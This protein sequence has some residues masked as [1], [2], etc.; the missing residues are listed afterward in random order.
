MAITKRMSINK[1]IQPTHWLGCGCDQCKKERLARLE[2]KSLPAGNGHS[3]HCS[4][5]QCKKPYQQMPY[6]YQVTESCKHFRQPV[7]VGDFTVTCSAWRD[8]PKGNDKEK[9]LETIKTPDIGIYL[10]SLWSDIV[11]PVK[12]SPGLNDFPVCKAFYPTILFPWRDRGMPSDVMLKELMEY[13]IKKIKEGKSI[14]IGCHGGH[15]RTGT[16]VACLLTQLTN[17]S[18][19][20]IITY[21]RTQYCKEAIEGYVQEDAIYKLKGEEPPKIEKPA[22]TTTC[23]S[24]STKED[25][26]ITKMKKLPARSRILLLEKEEGHY[27]YACSECTITI[28]AK[29][30]LYHSCDWKYKCC[31]LCYTAMEKQAAEDVTSEQWEMFVCNLK[32]SYLTCSSCEVPILYSDKLWAKDDSWTVIMCD[33]CYSTQLLKEVKQDNL[34]EQ[35]QLAEILGY[36][37]AEELAKDVSDTLANAA[38][39]GGKKV[40]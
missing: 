28:P 19:K 11:D 3:P 30:A 24:S 2:Q 4:C 38:K 37:S 17:M 18:A 21:V 13:A 36:E 40:G 23:Y 39:K 31:A 8:T 16:F 32:M 27:D 34:L 1:I 35:S 10:D 12:V 6:L 14:D 22:V 7:K 29:N 5:W 9:T 15:G 20:E 26:A 25:D 33:S